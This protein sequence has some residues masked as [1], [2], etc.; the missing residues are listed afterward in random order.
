MVS[1][2]NSF[3]KLEFGTDL[4][5]SSQ[6]NQSDSIIISSF[7]C[8]DTSDNDLPDMKRLVSLANKVLFS[9]F[10]IKFKSFI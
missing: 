1:F 4:H 8:S 9:L 3:A 5:I 6:I 7:I 10:D 2:E